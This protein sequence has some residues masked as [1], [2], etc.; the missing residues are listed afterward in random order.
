MAE[1]KDKKTSLFREKSLERIESPEKLNDYLRVTSPGVWLLLATVI[2]VLAGVC[3]WGIFGRI[4]ATT[5]AAVVTK[6]GASTCL[7]PLSALQGAIEHHTVL[8]DGEEIELL[9][10]EQEPQ[11]ITE[12]TDIYTM[13]AGNLSPG[14]IVYPA[15]LAQPLEED[16]VVSGK[17]LTETISPASLYFDS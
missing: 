6:E 5:S 14:D 12:T 17:L 10:F 16:G 8:V 7:V 4:D 11:T 13:L 1:N 15:A 2:I 3:V 9:P